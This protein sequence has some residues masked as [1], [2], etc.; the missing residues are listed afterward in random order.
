M[1]A[2]GHRPRHISRCQMCTLVVGGGEEGWGERGGAL[3]VLKEERGGVRSE[4]VYYDHSLMG[5]IIP[6]ET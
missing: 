6:Q 1:M 2:G 3:N 4:S 5:R